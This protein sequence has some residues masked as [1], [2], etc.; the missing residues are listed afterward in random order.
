MDVTYDVALECC[1]MYL[2][3]GQKN[4][5]KTVILQIKHVDSETRHRPIVSVG[6]MRDGDCK[7]YVVSVFPACTI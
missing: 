7:T 2:K 1:I 4:K 3:L 6:Q 5:T